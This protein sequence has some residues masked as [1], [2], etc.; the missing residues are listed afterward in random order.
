[1]NIFQKALFWLSLDSQQKKQPLITPEIDIDS[2]VTINIGYADD[3]DHVVRLFQDNPSNTPYE[4]AEHV[5]VTGTSRREY[6]DL[7][8]SF[9]LGNN[10]CIALQLDPD[11]QYD[12]NAIKV[13]GIW[14]DKK[15]NKNR[16]QIG[17][18]DANIVK[19]ISE[20]AKKAILS[21]TIKT[22][23]KPRDDKD[24]GIRIKI[25]SSIKP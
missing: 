2:F 10:Q 5:T 19:E 7:A 17:W 25:W 22:L 6:S 3:P 16:E 24:A 8:R 18:V 4:I 11:N 1:M 20:I 23:Y 21:A 9:V 14:Q 13:I 15:G 12:Q